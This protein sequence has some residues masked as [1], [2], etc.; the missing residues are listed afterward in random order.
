MSESHEAPKMHSH[1]ISSHEFGPEPASPFAAEAAPDVEG[2][3]GEP[4]LVLFYEDEI[5]EL[6]SDGMLRRETP[7]R[8]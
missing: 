2:D 3:A 7:P 6:L 5:A 4:L 1:P 8:P